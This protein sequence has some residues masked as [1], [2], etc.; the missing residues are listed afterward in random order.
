MEKG[1]GFGWGLG[2]GVNYHLISNCALA[3][4]ISWLSKRKEIDV[5]GIGYKIIEELGWRIGAYK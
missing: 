1:I 2:W 4:E 5:P 3:S